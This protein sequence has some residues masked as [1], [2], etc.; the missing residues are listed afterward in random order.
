MYYKP[1]VSN[2]VEEQ[3]DAN[4]FGGGAVEEW[5]KGLITRGKEAMADAARWEQW[6]APMPQGMALSQVLREYDVPSFSVSTG[7]PYS[8][9]AMPNGSQPMM[10]MNGKHLSHQCGQSVSIVAFLSTS[11]PIS[12]FSATFKRYSPDLDSM[13]AAGNI[14]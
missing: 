6:A 1:D 11:L 4:S 9:S 7:M 13:N 3:S 2:I 5:K 8:N 14:P 10:T 12:E